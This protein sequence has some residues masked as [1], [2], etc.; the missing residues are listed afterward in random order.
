MALDY[1]HK[2]VNLEEESVAFLKPQGGGY[3]D[4]LKEFLDDRGISYV[5]ITR[6]ADWPEDGGSV[7]LS[8]FHSAKGLEFDYV[9]ILG[10]NDRNTDHAADQIDD[11]LTVL[12][13]LLAVAVARAR[14]AV[15]IGYKP[16]E[17]SDLVQ[18]FAEGTIQEIDLR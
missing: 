10:L 8:T 2:T 5:N 4:R 6:E 13:R 1:I 15:I 16:G 14:K 18:F 9:I 12:R 17:E 3:F 7:A 11:Q